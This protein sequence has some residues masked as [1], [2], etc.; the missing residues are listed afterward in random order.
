M[1]THAFKYVLKK[2]VHIY[3][4]TMEYFSLLG[5]ENGDEFIEF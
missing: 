5:Q 4:H 2:D 1:S 3:N